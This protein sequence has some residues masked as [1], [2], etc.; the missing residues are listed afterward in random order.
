MSR[1]FDKVG[2]IELIAEPRLAESFRLLLPLPDLEAN[3]L[4]G[5]E[6]PLF[7]LVADGNGVILRWDG[8]L[9]NAQGAFDVGVTMR[10]DLTGQA[11]TF[12]LEVHN[13]T[14]LDLAE[15]WYP[16]LGGMMALGEPA[17]T[18]LFLPTA[19]WAAVHQPFV[20]FPES[21]APG[22]G[23]PGSRFPEFAAGYPGGLSMPWVDLYDPNLGRGVYLASHDVVPRFRVV[24]LEMHPGIKHNTEGS[25]WPRPEQADD[26]FPW[27]VIANWVYFPYTKPG[28]TFTGGR[29][30][31][32]A[33]EGDWHCAA[34]IYRAWFTS[35]FPLTDPRRSW[36][37]QHLAV[38]DSL[39]LLPEGNVV[40]TY[41]DIARWA[42]DA[43][44][45][46][47]RSVLISGWDVGGHDSHYPR[48]EPD[49]RLGTWEDLARAVRRCHEI[50]MRVFFFA[51]LSPV[52]CDTDW[53]RQE[54]HRY[55]STS[56]WGIT[57]RF[58]FG[59]GTLGARLGFAARPL[60]NASAGFPEYREII[61]RQMRRLA[62]IGGDGVHLDKLMPPAMDFNPELK[63]SPDQ[64]SWVGALAGLQE[65]LQ[66][67][68][69]VNPAFCLSV[70]SAWD[71]LLEYT[72]VAWVWHS[73]LGSPDHIPAFKYTFP[74]WLPS[75]FV[76]QAYDYNDVNNAVRFGYQ[77]YLGPGRYMASL[78]DEQTRPLSEYVREVLGVWE[79]LRGTI[80]DGEFLDREG[81]RVQA[82]PQVKYNTHRDP[83][84]GQRACV[85][86]NDG[87][88]AAEAYVA[89]EGSEGALVVVHQPFEPAA[90]VTSPAT[91]TIPPE[92]LAIV[93]ES[94]GLGDP[95]RRSDR[96]GD[97]A[98]T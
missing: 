65:I 97:P 84:T 27:G 49:P 7:S 55:R 53:Y 58:G 62:E 64:A 48:Y 10:V 11:V 63:L 95:D 85:L 38:Q 94:P 2:G 35:Q 51:N 50:G 32:Q 30:V 41:A 42:E 25:N 77:L 70:E 83:R 87:D 22:A 18:N 80:F 90:A 91:L 21:M 43:R 88:A 79:G 5:V 96:L 29:V 1:L 69:E 20:R 44:D 59:M 86:V 74:Q 73:N 12:D 13:R 78:A 15:V 24:R 31:L 26:R 67:C 16:M 23:V 36:M 33:H 89:F 4:L 72:D 82:A 75:M 57:D 47:V 45:Y 9:R 17:E 8:P 56:R 39:F 60:T 61:T 6:Q 68:R 93:V 54:L 66:A 34:R 14:E 3:Y 52:D 92:R 19:G 46:G 81:V 98:V 71:R 37:H 76:C 40:M 28:E